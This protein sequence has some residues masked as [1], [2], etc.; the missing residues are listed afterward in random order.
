M[1]AESDPEV[2]KAIERMPEAK[3][4]L[5]KSKKLIVMRT[6]RDR[7]SVEF[8]KPASSTNHRPRRGRPVLSSDRQKD[9]RPR[10]VRGGPRQR[11]AGRRTARPRGI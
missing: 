1:A 4:L 8:E 9:S 10:S 11:Y 6:N 2:I 3:T 5:E 7:A